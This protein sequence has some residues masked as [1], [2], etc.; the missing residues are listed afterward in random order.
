MYN[1]ISAT[2]QVMFGYNNT[3]WGKSCIGRRGESWS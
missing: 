1:Q 2:L 3:F